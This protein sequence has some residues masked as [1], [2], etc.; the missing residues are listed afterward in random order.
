MMKP[1]E[2]CA[3]G[4]GCASLGS[5]VGRAAGLRALAAAYERGVRWFDLA[6]SYGDGLAEE[7]F[8]EFAATRRNQL[9]ICTKVGIAPPSLSP[10]KRS[11]K[12]IARAILRAMPGLRRTV[13]GAR[14]VTRLDLTSAVVKQSL[15]SS[16]KAL[17]TDYVDVLALHDPEAAKIPDEVTRALEDCVASGKARTIGLTGSP[18]SIKGLKKAHNSLFR[19]LQMPADPISRAAEWLIVQ[20]RPGSF[21]LHSLGAAS[22]RTCAAVG[23]SDLAATTVAAEGFKG[24]T[25]RALQSALSQASLTFVERNGGILLRSMFHPQHLED[26]FCELEHRESREAGVRVVEKLGASPQPRG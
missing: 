19:H 22:E 7:V 14:T 18:D 3:L 11:A 24:N 13:A 15:E 20:E 6:P 23:R 10:L 26:N 25:D 17:R 4:F 1:H 2:Y 21:A 12:P 9:T 8:G 5:R 16:L